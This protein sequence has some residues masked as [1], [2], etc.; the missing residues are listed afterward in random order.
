MRWHIGLL[1]TLLLIGDI[2]S[3]GSGFFSEGFGQRKPGNLIQEL[4][5]PAG[6][7]SV[8]L[9]R[10]K[11]LGEYESPKRFYFY[12]C[13]GGG[14]RWISTPDSLFSDVG[15]LQFID[16][17]TLL[18]T[19]NTDTW[20]ATYLI[21]MRSMRVSALGSGGAT[22]I[23]SGRDAGLFRLSG[24]K[25]YAADDRGEPLGAYWANVLVD[26]QGDIVEM[27]STK[28]GGTCY[29]LRFLLDPK[30]HYPRLRQSF[31]TKVC[32]EQ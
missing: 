15:S 10:G 14:C 18:F 20:M 24:W 29:P 8:A 17:D 26:R 13:Q 3:A 5:S 6:S 27:L 9:F 28:T 7:H 30:G 21:D 32:V 25:G 16:E 2:A 12:L 22:Y 11:V 4:Q 19:A 23:R 1:I 31:D